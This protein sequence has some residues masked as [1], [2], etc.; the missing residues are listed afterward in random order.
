MKLLFALAFSVS[1][2]RNILLSDIH[3]NDAK[4]EYQ[5][6]KIQSRNGQTI[7]IIIMTHKHAGN[8]EENY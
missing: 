6:I 3:T 2:F 1:H 4:N 5:P 8:V 7:I